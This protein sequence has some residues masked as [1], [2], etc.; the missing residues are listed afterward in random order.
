M[1]MDACLRGNQTSCV[2]F[3]QDRVISNQKILERSKS[4]CIEVY[5][6]FQNRLMH[7]RE[8]LETIGKVVLGC[9]KNF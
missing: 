3:T 4:L 6:S 9:G 7:Y 2:F 8:R 1:E 5:Q